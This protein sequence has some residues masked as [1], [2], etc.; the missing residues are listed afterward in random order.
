MKRGNFCLLLGI[1][2]LLAAVGIAFGGG[3]LWAVYMGNSHLSP[4]E[5]AT[6]AVGHDL[7]SIECDARIPDGHKICRYDVGGE[8]GYIIPFLSTPPASAVDAERQ[9]LAGR[10]IHVISHEKTGTDDIYKLAVGKGLRCTV[11]VSRTKHGYWQNMPPSC[12][13]IGKDIENPQAVQKAKAY[14]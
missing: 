11:S 2:Y 13:Q 5:F 4:D 3:C 7:V 10:F 12:A 9:E 14:E 1:H 8:T 6:M